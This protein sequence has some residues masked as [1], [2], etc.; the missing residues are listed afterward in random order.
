MNVTRLWLS[1]ELR[2]RWPSLAALGL[3][4]ALA[5]G[6]TLTAF[7]GARR[8]ATAPDRSCAGHGR[9]AAQA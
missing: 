9:T 5:C 1:L 4:I 8:G 3:L 7:A 2:R 6:I